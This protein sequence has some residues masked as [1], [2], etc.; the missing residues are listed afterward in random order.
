MAHQIDG[1]AVAAFCEE[2][3]GRMKN[4]LTAAIYAGLRD[5]I[6]RGQFDIAARPTDAEKE[7]FAAKWRDTVKEQGR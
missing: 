1:D 3:A 4:P 5:R 6:R 7:A 2:R